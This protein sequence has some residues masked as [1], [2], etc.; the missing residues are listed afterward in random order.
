MF[1]FVEHTA[2][3]GIEAR[4]PSR[5]TVVEQL[6]MG[7]SHLMFGEMAGKPE[8]RKDIS[9]KAEEDVEMLVEWLN[10]ILYLCERDN[11]VPAM[12]QVVKFNHHELRGVMA[13]ESFDSTRHS[14][15]HQVKSVTYHQACLQ[16]SDG[17]WYARI[18]VDL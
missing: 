1:R 10:E 16:E 4:A 13:G 14:I 11:F 2:D 18:Y 15:D 6:S 12:F 3:M 7:L 9:V 8:C 5:V 17:H